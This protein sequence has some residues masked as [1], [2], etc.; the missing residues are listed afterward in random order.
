MRGIWAVLLVAV[1][2]T[3]TSAEAQVR[4][5]AI[6]THGLQVTVPDGWSRAGL[7]SN[8]SDPRQVLALAWPNDR[9]VILV[10]ETHDR[11][12][13]S[14]SSFQ[15]PSRPT[16]LEGCCDQPSGPG[17]RFAFRERGREFYAY[18]FSKD[19]AAAHSAVAVLNTLRVS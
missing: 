18:V 7:L 11:L 12:F 3:G 9:A 6:S 10:L 8:C 19:R 16:R 15:L 1:G 17:Y 5:H 2:L 4:T 13:A 14:R